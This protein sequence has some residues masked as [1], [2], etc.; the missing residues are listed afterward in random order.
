MP[1]SATEFNTLPCIGIDI[2]QRKFGLIWRF[3]DATGHPFSVRPNVVFECDSVALAR[4]LCRHGV[5][6]G[7]FFGYQVVDDI[8]AGT[9][10]PVLP[11][12]DYPLRPISLLWPPRR[13]MPRRMRAVLRHIELGIRQELDSMRGLGFEPAR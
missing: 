9:L 7:A 3:R 13:P 6:F 1:T 5:G 12:P 4:R 11:D 10:V 8:R 2:S